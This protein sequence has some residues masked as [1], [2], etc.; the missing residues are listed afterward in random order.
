MALTTQQKNL[1]L[2]WRAG[3][4]PSASDLAEID[5]T[6][7][8]EWLKQIFKQSSAQPAYI[9]VTDD[10]LKQLLRERGEKGYRSADV[11][12]NQRR[13]LREKSRDGLKALN[14][15]WLGQMVNSPQQLREKMSLFW[16]GHFATRTVNIIYQ[17]QLLDT[18]RKNALGNFATLLREVSKSASMI[19]FLNNNQNR[20]GHPN[21]NFAREVMELFTLGRGNYSENDVKE[22]ARSFTGWGA[23]A[24]GAFNF[25]KNQH[26]TGE[27]TIFGKTGAFSG[28]DTLNMLLEKRETAVFVARKVYKYFVNE[29][30]DEEKVN[31]LAA[32]FYKNNYDISALMND[33]FS[34][35]WFYSEKNIGSRIKSP[36]ELLAGIR[37]FLPMQIDNEEVQL[38]LQRYLGQVLFYPPNVAGWPGGRNW[39]DSSTLMMRLRIPQLIYE[40]NAFQAKP[41][42][43][44]DQMMGM[45]EKLPGVPNAGKKGDKK[46]PAQQIS[47]RIDWQPLLKDLEKVARPQLIASLSKLILQTE[48]GVNPSL[49]AVNADAESREIFIRTVTIQLMST[50]EYQLC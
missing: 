12:E 14:L 25:K 41:K 33:V 8:A 21:E 40:G 18:I 6:G 11:D 28:D 5:K 49:L 37:R 30:P 10:E 13:R 2:S 38:L 31:W 48:K 17:Q 19:N 23:D 7:N 29:I 9:D 34:A 15:A 43:D 39:I 1:H 3:F 27:K 46:R 47:A 24:S 44:D 32:R 16:H 4:G 50:P 22:A 36:V 42:D 26:D 35:D 20:K 45:M